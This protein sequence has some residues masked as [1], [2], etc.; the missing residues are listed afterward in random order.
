MILLGMVISATLYAQV[1]PGDNAADFTLLNV[2]SNM[3]SLSNYDESNGVILVF[4]CNTC[5]FAQV[6]EQRLIRIHNFYAQKGYPVIAINPNDEAVSPDDSFEDMIKLAE[7]NDYPFPYLKDATQEV[8]KA[9]GAS[10]TPQIFLLKNEGGQFKVAYTGA[11]DNNVVDQRGVTNRYLEKA[12]A[13]VIK[14]KTPDPITVDAV[15]CTIK[16]R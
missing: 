11:I 1:Q 7:K 8:Y 12:I 14:G 9:Y 16:S 13:A 10:R 15:G 4:T 6:Y 5:P 2:D 3:V